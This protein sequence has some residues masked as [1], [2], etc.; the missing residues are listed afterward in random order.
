[1]TEREIQ[2]QLIGQRSRLVGFVK[3]KVQDIDLAEDI[4]QDSL[5]K[6]IRYAPQLQDDVKLLPWFYRI[7]DHAIIDAY[8][9]KRRLSEREA[10]YAN[11]QENV[12]SENDLSATCECLYDLVKT[13]KPEYATVLEAIDLHEEDPESVARRL[14]VTVGNLRVRSHRARQQLRSKLEEVCRT[15]AKHGCLDCTCK[16]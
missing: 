6:A 9:K 3:V 11:E 8:R 2:D 16:D 13:M 1:V 7:V 12:L 15:C 14:G 5:L 10:S 4:I